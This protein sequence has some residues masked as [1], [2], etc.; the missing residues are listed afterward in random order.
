M[1]SHQCIIPSL[2]IEWKEELNCRSSVSDSH[3]Q[4]SVH[5][6][7]NSEHNAQ[8]LGW[9]VQDLIKVDFWN[10]TALTPCKNTTCG[11][12]PKVDLFTDGGGTACTPSSQLWAWVSIYLH[13]AVHTEEIWI[14]PNFRRRNF[15]QILEMGHFHTWQSLHGLIFCIYVWR[16]D[17]VHLVLPLCYKSWTIFVS[18][19]P[20]GKVGLL[21]EKM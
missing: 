11:P 21:K 8:E 9:G 4:F 7:H 20:E 5:I 10:L 12:W 19:N 3:S 17:V 6:V 15:P 2:K 16:N 14:G 1:S 13:T 18:W